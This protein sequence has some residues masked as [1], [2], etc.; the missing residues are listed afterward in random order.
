MTPTAL[1]LLHRL[2]A[3][4]DQ[5]QANWCVP[6]NTGRFLYVMALTTGAKRI[7]E[8]GTS[9][10]YSTLWLAEAA[11]QTGGEI[12]TL[13]CSMERQQQA[14][15]H[16]QE[17][18]H[19]DIVRFHLGQALDLLRGFQERRERFDFAFIDAAKKEYL[20]YVQLLESMMPS[21]ACFI[22]DNTRSHRSEMLDFLEAM[23]TS[24]AFDVAEIDT[25]NGQLLARKR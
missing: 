17:A 10:G 15:A 2:E 8:V 22:A 5:L 23:T 13:D 20:G 25:P 18:G 9:I 7:C 16:I 24:T 4:P 1:D 3:T 6:P 21:G 19:G 12:D 14:K 11:R